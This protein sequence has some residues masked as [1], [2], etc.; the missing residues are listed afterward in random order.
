MKNRAKILT[1]FI[2]SQK[3]REISM[4]GGEK[5]EVWQTQK[6]GVALLPHASSIRWHK[7]TWK[8]ISREGKASGRMKNIS[9]FKIYHCCEINEKRGCDRDAH[10]KE[11]NMSFICM[12]FTFLINKSLYISLF[13]L[14]LINMKHIVRTR[15]IHWL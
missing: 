6:R 11:K 2:L 15:F 13:R 7:W 10:T 5:S 12:A 14:Q 8:T 3:R 4:V 9:K 1:N